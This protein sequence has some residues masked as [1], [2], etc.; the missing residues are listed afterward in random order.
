MEFADISKQNPWWASTSVI[1]DDPKLREFDTADVKWMPRLRKYMNLDA[2]VLYS[3]RGPRQVGKT[4]LAKLIIRDELNRRNPADILYYSCDLLTDPQQMAGL[5]E[6][7]LRWSNER[8]RG[9]KLI[10][11]DEISKVK[12]WESAYKH[13]IDTYGIAKKT[14]I[15]TGSSC[16]DIK[17]GVERLPG[18][19]GEATGEQNHKILLPMKFAEYVNLRSP[20]IRAV[21]EAAKLDVSATRQ[22]ALLELMT[23]KAE[24]WVNPL[25]PHLLELQSLLDEYFI[26]GGIM[27]AVNQYVRDKEIKNTTYEL[28]L[29]MFFGDLAKLGRDE[30]TAKKLLSAVLKHAPSP[31]GWTRI[32]TEMG[33]PQPVTVSQYAEV[34]NTLF[35]LNIYHSFDINRN[36]PNQ[37]SDK[38]LQI[39]NPFF[40][41]AFRGHIENPA[42]DYY[43][44]AVE[45]LMNGG[46]PLL[47]EFVTGDHLARCAYNAHPTDLYDQSNSVFYVRN[48]RGEAIDFILRLPS[49]FLPVEVKYQ[50]QINSQDYKNLRHHPQGVLVTKQTVDLK[51]NHP[52]IPMPIFLLFI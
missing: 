1:N 24:N 5:L 17:H 28:Y 3:M 7:F 2:D 43:R 14:F 46:K 48:R 15:L 33:I 13:I 45:Y 12:D 23:L 52:A 22:G 39:P 29:Q 30:S 11:L 38:K 8:S 50:N 40:F 35:V 9:R 19:K 16:W 26:T 34:L 32:H 37:R 6:T 49:M 20:R 36:Q 44:Q 18:R 41:H 47:A 31:V 21:V 27:G 10:I 4:T 51:E 25:L 42:G